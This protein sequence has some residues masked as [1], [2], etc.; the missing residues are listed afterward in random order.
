MEKVDVGRVDL[1]RAFG[2][3]IATDRFSAAVG[4]K[5]LYDLAL[6]L[7]VHPFHLGVQPEP[8]AKVSIPDGVELHVAEAR[9]AWEALNGSGRFQSVL[10]SGT[11]RAVVVCEHRSIRDYFPHDTAD[12]FRGVFIVMTGGCPDVAVREFL[13]LL[14]V[15]PAMSNKPFLY[16]SDCDP[17]AIEMYGILKYGSK[18]HA[19]AAPTMTC[20]QLKWAVRQSYPARRSKTLPS[21]PDEA[22]KRRAIYEGQ[23]RSAIERVDT[24]LKKRVLSTKDKQKVSSL[25]KGG[26]YDDE[27]ETDVLGEL[28]RLKNGGRKVGL[29]DLLKPDPNGVTG[30]LAEIVAE[31]C[32]DDPKL[33]PRQFPHV[34]EVRK[35]FEAYNEVHSDS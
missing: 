25:I 14:S 11:I 21:N 22:I 6:T 28:T 1:L 4:R 15:H 13:H 9:S 16:V 8:T 18:N 24:L 2:S 3:G 10:S 12:S 17:S 5:F 20:S 19:F 27:Q 34:S 7:D 32:G 33:L 35:A 29:F 30:L 31:A 26:Y 23:A